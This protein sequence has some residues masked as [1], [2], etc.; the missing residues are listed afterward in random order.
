MSNEGADKYKVIFNREA[1]QID[2]GQTNYNALD[3]KGGSAVIPTSSPQPSSSLDTISTGNVLI[4]DTPEES[5]PLKEVRHDPFGKYR[6]MRY[7]E[8]LSLIILIMV[9]VSTAITIAL[10]VQIKQGVT[11]VE[12]HGAVMSSNEQCSQ[13]GLKL[14]QENEASTVDSVVAAT[15]CL[16]VLHPHAAGIGGGG[17]MIVHDVRKKKNFTTNFDFREQSGSNSTINEKFQG[18]LKSEINSGLQVGI[19]GVLHGLYEA[20]KI[21][22]RLDWSELVMHAHEMAASSNNIVSKEL[23]GAIESYK[24]SYK[25]AD[26]GS[27]L[28]EGDKLPPQAELAETL[29]KVAESGPEAVYDGEIAKSIVDTINSNKGMASLGDMASYECKHTRDQQTTELGDFKLVMGSNSWLN[30]AVKYVLSIIS[31]N[32]ENKDVNIEEFKLIEALRYA[33]ANLPRGVDNSTGNIDDSENKANINISKSYKSEHY[34]S[35]F[36]P[37]DF[38]DNRRNFVTALGPDYIAVSLSISLG[39]AF[40]SG[41][42]TKGILLNNAM[43]DFSWEDKISNEFGLKYSQS[44]KVRENARPASPLLPIITIPK[45]SKCGTY[46]LIGEAGISTTSLPSISRVL[47]SLSNGNGINSA[48]SQPRYNPQLVE[49]TL[50]YEESDGREALFRIL[51]T[52]SSTKL[53]KNEMNTCVCGINRN[54]EGLSVFVDTRMNDNTNT[55]VF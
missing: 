45:H 8:G 18:K 40:G 41:L 5:S 32:G 13:L 29:K 6:F 37:L 22:G 3:T 49:R 9:T 20:H 38:T 10:I 52:D 15:L 43:L 4:M 16:C 46:N 33:Q 54:S 44:N 25:V 53:I 55:F 26:D 31:F 50:K 47:M 34:L 27:K 48:I 11:Q 23:A 21:F 42:H 19:P 28:V 17:Y 1:G 14:M 12:P 2:T 36:E 7:L 35:D 30:A 24:G 51:E 39:S